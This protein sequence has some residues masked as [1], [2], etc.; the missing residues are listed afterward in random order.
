MRVAGRGRGTL[1]G[2]KQF[3]ISCRSPTQDFFFMVVAFFLAKIFGNILLSLNFSLLSTCNFLPFSRFPVLC[4]SFVL[5][6]Q[7]L[8]KLMNLMCTIGHSKVFID[9]VTQKAGRR[10]QTVTRNMCAPLTLMS[11]H[12]FLL[13]SQERDL[14]I[15]FG[16]SSP[17]L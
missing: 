17:S 7:I 11:V 8:P 6:F 15:I 4:K 10:V 13:M 5:C 14:G 3:Y 16:F 12:T 1:S 9:D 2:L